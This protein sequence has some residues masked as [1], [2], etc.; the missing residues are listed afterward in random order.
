MALGAKPI[1]VMRMVLRQG[2]VLTGFGLLAGSA[3][4]V[5]LAR[6]VASVSY[7]NSAMGSSAR[8]LASSAA[9]PLLYLAAAAF[10]CCIAVFATLIPARRAA[11]V[12]PM[13]A[14]RNE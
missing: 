14:L 11:T 13:Q 10:L 1:D 5:L 12:N 7:T 2:L 9:N 8:L 3:L 4:A 6:A